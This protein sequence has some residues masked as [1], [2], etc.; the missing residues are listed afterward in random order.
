VR[1]EILARVAAVG[2]ITAGA[3]LTAAR[4]PSLPMGLPGTSGHEVMDPRHVT[5]AVVRVFGHGV[6]G[7]ITGSEPLPNLGRTAAIV[8]TPVGALWL[9]EGDGQ[10]ILGSF[11][12]VPPG[13]GMPMVSSTVM[14]AKAQVLVDRVYPWAATLTPTTQL[15]SHGSF[16]TYEIDWRQ[17]INGVLMPSWVDVTADADGDIVAFSANHFVVSAPPSPAVTQDQATAIALATLPARTSLQRA[18]LKLGMVHG[19][20]RLYWDMELLTAPDPTFTGY[21]DLPGHI[22]MIDALTGTPLRPSP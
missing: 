16:A 7:R 5:D 8:T 15:V 18:T 21:A 2:V 9:L 6:F 13:R 14:Q 17:S 10:V 19:A 1:P 12:G 3:A 22:V 11:G 4:A 20:M